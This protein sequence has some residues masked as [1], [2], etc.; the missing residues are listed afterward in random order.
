MLKR[1]RVYICD[2]CGIVALQETYFF[3][4]DVWKD[5]P[6]GWT[7]LGKADLCPI[8][9]KAYKRFVEELMDSYKKC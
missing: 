3:M 8:C 1:K 9:S 4:G 7:R 2:Y 5:A 6:E